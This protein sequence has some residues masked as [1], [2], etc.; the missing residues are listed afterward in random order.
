MF[1]FQQIGKRQEK[2]FNDILKMFLK[3]KRQ[4]SI[5]GTSAIYIWIC[6]VSRKNACDLFFLHISESVIRSTVKVTFIC[7]STWC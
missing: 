4:Y 2:T 3:L 1:E 6:F 5:T 7:L